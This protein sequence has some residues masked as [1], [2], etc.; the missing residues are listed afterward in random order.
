MGCGCSSM[1]GF[2]AFGAGPEAGTT[3]PTVFYDFNPAGPV[4]CLRNE[5][6][7][8]MKG[9]LDKAQALVAIDPKRPD[10]VAVTNA[11]QAPALYNGYK[12]IPWA[13]WVDMKVK[14]GKKVAAAGTVKGQIQKEFP[15]SLASMDLLTFIAAA[16][17][18]ALASAETLYA[19]AIF[20]GYTPWSEGALAEWK[21]KQGGGGG[22]ST[23]SIWSGPV[24]Y[25][26][27]GAIVLGI[28]AFALSKKK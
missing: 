4:R 16:D 24:P 12:T 14:E 7:V 6:Y 17:E 13:Q 20:A 28:G 26:I 19:P 3:T 1:K 23:A 21:A 5:A 22:V 18:H 15:S 11:I 25:L 2:G 27:G 9:M 10:F 8:E